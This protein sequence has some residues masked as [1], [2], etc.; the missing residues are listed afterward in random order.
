MTNTSIDLLNDRHDEVIITRLIK[1]G[2][3]NEKTERSCPSSCTETEID[4]I[5][6]RVT[7]SLSVKFECT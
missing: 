5:R 4:K 3:N 2:G 6:V 1:F 7:K